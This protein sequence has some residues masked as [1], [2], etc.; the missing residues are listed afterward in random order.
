MKFT[1]ANVPPVLFLFLN[2]KK[3]KLKWLVDSG[4]E[5]NITASN[6]SNI[7]PTTAHIQNL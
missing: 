4:D 7:T 5:L 3:V 1:K 2:K 6:H